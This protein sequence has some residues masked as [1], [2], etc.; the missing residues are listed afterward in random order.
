[1]CLV[2]DLAVCVLDVK[3]RGLNLE[4]D[5]L[6]EAR[7][8]SVEHEVVE[9]SIEIG[10]VGHGLALGFLK[11]LSPFFDVLTRSHELRLLDALDDVAHIT[12]LALG[13]VHHRDVGERYFE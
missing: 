2:V 6:H 4:R 9:H 5:R 1:M 13:F 3:R 11:R 7:E 10:A 8:V 12:T